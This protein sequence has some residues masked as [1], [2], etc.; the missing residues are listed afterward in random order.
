MQDSTAACEYA[1]CLLKARYF[2]SVRTPVELI[3]TLRHENGFVRRERHLD[4]MQ[5]SAR[6][7]DLPFD[8]MAAMR[9]LDEAV[10]QAREP[11]RVRLALDETGAFDCTIAPIGAAPAQLELRDLTASREQRR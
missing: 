1:E 3:E 6:F 4:R 10:A 9:A 5:R 7:L 11:L 2:E 8:R